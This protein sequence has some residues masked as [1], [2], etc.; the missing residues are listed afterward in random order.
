MSTVGSPST[1]HSASCHPAPPAAVMP[2]LWPSLS[3]KFFSPGAG[4]TIGFPSGVYAI[5]PLY[6]SLIPTS[7]NAGTRF[8]QRSICGIMRSSSPLNN[9]Y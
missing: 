8:I 1:I 2:K 5:A 4:P 3:Q 9:S 6:T 7:P